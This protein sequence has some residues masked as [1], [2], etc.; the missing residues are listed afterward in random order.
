MNKNNASLVS[1]WL[2]ILESLPVED[3]LNNK[4][5]ILRRTFPKVSADE[6]ASF[7]L[8][9]DKSNKLYTIMPY[10]LTI[11]SKGYQFWI[12]FDRSCNLFYGTRVKI[13]N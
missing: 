7:S 5:N 3:E 6:K 10:G 8:D 13:S 1:R 12:G 4:V 11:K 9:I 2:E